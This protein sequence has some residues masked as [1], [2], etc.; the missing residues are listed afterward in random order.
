MEVLSL[1]E[2]LN[3]IAIQQ[4]QLDNVILWVGVQFAVWSF[5]TFSG[6]STVF[7]S[8]ELADTFIACG[9][10]HW[11][12]RKT[13]SEDAFKWTYLS[14]TDMLQLGGVEFLC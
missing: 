5:T 4:W 13:M 10:S 9:T 8:V 3:K 7:A 12:G 1:W 11:L 2:V 6:S 14:D